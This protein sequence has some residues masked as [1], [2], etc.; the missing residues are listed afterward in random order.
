MFEPFT[1]SRSL[2]RTLI[3]SIIVT[4]FVVMGG[5]TPNPHYFVTFLVA[6]FWIAV[7]HWAITG[8]NDGDISGG[9]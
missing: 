1:F 5:S 8:F 6:W 3:A 7:S 4:L 2:A 9:D